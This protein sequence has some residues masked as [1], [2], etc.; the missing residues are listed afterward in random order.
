M[1]LDDL[2]AGGWYT[3]DYLLDSGGR[4]T[5]GPACYLCSSVEHETLW[6]WFTKS[7][8]SAPI[9]EPIPFEYAS[10]LEITRVTNPSEFP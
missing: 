5:F 3:F 4:R 1:T 2:E 9:R 6:F 7:L 8:S 10:F